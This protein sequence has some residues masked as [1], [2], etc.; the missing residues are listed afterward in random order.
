MNA[1]PGLVLA[2]GGGGARGLA[3]LGVLQV[4]ERE[5]IPVL[6]IAGTSM[7]GLL[8]A[9][10]A[11]S[12]PLDVI[13]TT[14]AETA[15]PTELLSMLG[16]SKSGISVRGQKLYALLVEALGGDLTFDELRFPLAL[17]AADLRSGQR[18]VLDDRGVV[19]AVR[20]TIAIPGVFEPVERQGPG[21]LSMQLID[22]GVL[23]NL[24][25]GAARALAPALGGSES[26]RDGAS[27][28]AVDVL[29]C[30]DENHLGDEPIVLPLELGPVPEVFSTLLQTGMMAIAGMTS[31][32]LQ[33]EPADLV[34]R[35]EIAPSITI[36][37]GFDQAEDVVAAG[38]KAA[39]ARLPELR[40]LAGM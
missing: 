11:A 17:V 25:V 4:L 19:D 38:R 18:V 40:R 12:V 39:E 33:L 24:P 16:I 35:P 9:L 8:G 23:D 22:G 31:L 7:G 10:Y 34:L 20:A 32:R 29:P 6:G 21:R 37:T 27:V 36:L 2:L 13:E 30:F 14:I 5:G 28:V 26:G 1:V 15:K 3:H